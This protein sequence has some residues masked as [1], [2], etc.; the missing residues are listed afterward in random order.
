MIELAEN[1]GFLPQMLKSR[2]VE[3]AIIAPSLLGELAIVCDAAELEAREKW[4]LEITDLVNGFYLDGANRIFAFIPAGS[5][6]TSLPKWN[7][8]ESVATLIAEPEINNVTLTPALEFLMKDNRQPLYDFARLRGRSRAEFL[9]SFKSF[10]DGRVRSF[11][12]LVQVF[13]DVTLTR[14]DPATNS[15]KGLTHE[16]GLGERRGALSLPD[17]LSS[18]L[19]IRDSW[20]FKDLI[21]LVDERLNRQRIGVSVLMVQLYR[22]TVALLTKADD[23][24]FQGDDLLYWA[25]LLIGWEERVIQGAAPAAFDA[26]CRAYRAAA[27]LP[28]QRRTLDAFWGEIAQRA[29]ICGLDR[30]VVA[31]AHMIDKL[32][33]NLVNAPAL[34]IAPWR[35]RL[36]STLERPVSAEHNYRPGHKTP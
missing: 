15:F 2:S 9:D 3:Y 6:A 5:F 14:I 30:V 12:E 28:T 8:I 11:A 4:K 21:R 33:A 23:L 27:A 7:T 31:R 26:L 25:A 36:R 32:S 1:D 22:A 24:A 18:F 35:D 10:V 13:N 19:E 29:S 17:R 34:P 16:Q 20:A